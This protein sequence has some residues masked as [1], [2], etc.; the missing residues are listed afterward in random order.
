MK[1]GRHKIP[2]NEI[3]RYLKLS[4]RRMQNF[5]FFYVKSKRHEILFM[6]HC[7]EKKR[8]ENNFYGGSERLMGAV[9][10]MKVRQVGGK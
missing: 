2:C 9:L 8:C 6:L 1:K 3:L 4:C 5:F 10:L 7:W